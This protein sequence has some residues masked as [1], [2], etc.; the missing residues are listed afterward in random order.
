MPE[1][2]TA[3]DVFL[4]RA[5]V[6]VAKRRSIV[7]SWLSLTTEDVDKDSDTITKDDEPSENDALNVL[8]DQ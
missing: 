1:S 7:K 6:A 3:A 5:S 8:P 4:N 2:T